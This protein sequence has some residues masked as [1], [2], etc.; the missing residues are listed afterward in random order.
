MYDNMPRRER[1][2]PA[3][4]VNMSKVNDLRAPALCGSSFYC[5]RHLV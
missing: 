2:T 4:N 3:N 1:L 5:D